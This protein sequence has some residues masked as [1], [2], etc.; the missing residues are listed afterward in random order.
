MAAGPYINLGMRKHTIRMDRT[1]S[2]DPESRGKWKLEVNQSPSTQNLVFGDDDQIRIQ[3]AAEA[4]LF[5]DKG[6]RIALSRDLLFHHLNQRVAGVLMQMIDCHNTDKYYTIGRTENQTESAKA[7]VVIPMD[8]PSVRLAHAAAHVGTLPCVWAYPRTQWD[9]WKR[10]GNY[11]ATGKPEAEVFCKYSDTYYLNNA[12]DGVEEVVNRADIDLDGNPTERQI[13]FGQPENKLRA[14]TINLFNRVA[15]N[16]INPVQGFALYLTRLEQL[17]E[18]CKER[19]QEPDKVAIFAAW[20]EDIATILA[21]YTRDRDLYLANLLG[22]R[23]DAQERRSSELQQVLFPKMFEMLQRKNLYQ[24]QIAARVDELGQ[25]I[26]DAAPRRRPRLFDKALKWALLRELDQVDEKVHSLFQRYYNCNGKSLEDLA[27]ERNGPARALVSTPRN[28]RLIKRMFR[29][30]T[31]YVDNFSIEEKCFRGDLLKE[32]RKVKGYSL[33][34]FC[35]AHNGRFPAAQRLN[36][37][38][39]RRYE[40]GCA[41]INEPLIGR[42][43]AILNVPAKI[44]YTNLAEVAR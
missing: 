14:Y 19:A 2:P 11:N 23:L 36:Y 37:E 31:N 38:Q 40:F 29:D 27:Q 20:G 41:R 16:E 25:Q 22:I 4:A 30:F 28:R 17:I 1:F 42:M 6:A 9:N 21:D 26:L 13:E 7:V 32:L 35:L 12:C 18:G 39:L 8:G 34:R 15:R 44:F 43:A 24:N 5:A 10:R 33:R 3:N